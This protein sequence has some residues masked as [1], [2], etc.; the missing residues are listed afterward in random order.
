MFS[1]QHSHNKTTQQQEKTTME[2]K[3]PNPICRPEGSTLIFLAGSI[4]MGAAE[5]W[6][7][8]ISEELMNCADC[9]G[10]PNKCPN[11]PKIVILNPRRD[12]WDSTWV[13]SPDNPQFREQVEWELAALEEADLIA[14]YF[15]PATKSPISLLEL[16]LYA[17]CGG[18]YLGQKSTKLVVCCPDGFWRKGNVQ[19]VCERYGIPLFDDK[20]TFFKAVKDIAEH[21]GELKSVNKEM[22]KAMEENSAFKVSVDTKDLEAA[23]QID[24][25]KALRD[26]LISLMAEAKEAGVGKYNANIGPDAAGYRMALVD[27]IREISIALWEARRDSVYM[28]AVNFPLKG[29]ALGVLRLGDTKGPLSSNPDVGTASEPGV[30][31]GPK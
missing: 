29:P 22:N 28:G 3:A 20:G 15:D 9:G 13:Q 18:G 5:K 24:P 25:Y 7:D 26:T 30:D 14:L 21:Y 19:L 17:K 12:D 4:E 27:K 31:C 8:R 23:L 16:G 6:Q 11:C 1:H 2:I 10:G